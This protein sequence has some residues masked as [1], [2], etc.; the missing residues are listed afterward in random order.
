[1]ARDAARQEAWV[2]RCLENQSSPQV[3]PH[4][5]P[6][7]P[8][9]PPRPASATRLIKFVGRKAGSRSTFCQ[10][11]GECGSVE[12]ESED[13][14]GNVTSPTSPSPQTSTVSP[15]SPTST[16]SPPPTSAEPKV[17]KERP[18]RTSTIDYYSIPFNGPGYDFK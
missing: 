7:P 13:G 18:K 15:S 9:P 12:S 17:A 5:P 2:K 1:M 4:P 16:T 6:P 8:P 14:Q 3:P 11:D 10:L